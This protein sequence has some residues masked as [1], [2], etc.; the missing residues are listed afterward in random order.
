[1]LDFYRLR[2]EQPGE[3]IR[4]VSRLMDRYLGYLLIFDRDDRIVRC[5]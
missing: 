3:Y 5:V 2:V 4:I 1:M